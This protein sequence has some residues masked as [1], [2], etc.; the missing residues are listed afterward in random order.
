M[1]NQQTSLLI[2]TNVWLDYYLPNREGGYEATALVGFAFEY[3]YPLLYPASIAKDVFY[4]SS[5]AF[6]KTIRAEKGALSSSDAAVAA[7]AAWKCV[8]NM[9]EQATA[10]GSDE[11][12][13]WMACK[14]RSIHNDLEDNLVVAAA[15]R[16]NATY[17]VTNDETLIK[18]SPV[19]ALTPRD[20]LAL[21]Q[22][23]I[24]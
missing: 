9:R 3:G 21:L 12:D 22:A 16:A 8:Q 10:V 11:S 24:A 2:D 7:E 4:L 23:E 20:A 17:L 13:L 18:H 1:P 19:A 5:H 6:R 14:L 15:K